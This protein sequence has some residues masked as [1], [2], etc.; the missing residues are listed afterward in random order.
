MNTVSS[1]NKLFNIMELK[2]MQNFQN[3]AREMTLKFHLLSLNHRTD[4]T[5]RLDLLHY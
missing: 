1:V 5:L 4:L 2:C 3:A